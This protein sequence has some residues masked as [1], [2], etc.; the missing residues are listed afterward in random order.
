MAAMSRNLLVGTCPKVEK[1]KNKKGNCWK[2]EETS[3]A[4][5]YWY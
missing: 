5:Y 1:K 3:Y 2:V 4:S